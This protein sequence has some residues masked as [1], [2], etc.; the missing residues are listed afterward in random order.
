MARFLVVHNVVIC[1]HI[2]LKLIV[3]VCSE[4]HVEPVGK[5]KKSSSHSNDSAPA[6][7]K[8]EAVGSFVCIFYKGLHF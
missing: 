2:L 4:F 5:K 7:V 8:R 1:I 6:L 3:I